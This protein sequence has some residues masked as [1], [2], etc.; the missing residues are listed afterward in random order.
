IFKSITGNMVNLD[1]QHVEMR[2]LLPVT[3]INLGARG[4]SIHG[5]ALTMTAQEDRRR[6]ETFFA[7]AILAPST[8]K[9]PSLVDPTYDAES[10]FTGA[11][12][13]S[14]ETRPYFLSFEAPR[15]PVDQA[16]RLDAGIYTVEVRVSVDGREWVSKATL[17][18]RVTESTSRSFTRFGDAIIRTEPMSALRQK[19]LPSDRPD[20][21]D[22]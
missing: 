8:G 2:I 7:R 18:I 19:L 13:S 20:M 4:G 22:Y 9:H 15:R 10:Y 11:Y 3:L 21:V 1:E 6:Y 16:F 12:L 14:R 5:L 17:Y